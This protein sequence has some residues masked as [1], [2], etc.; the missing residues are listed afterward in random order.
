MLQNPTRYSIDIECAVKRPVII[1]TKMFADRIKHIGGQWVE[2]REPLEMCGAWCS[3][4]RIQNRD[5][6]AAT[7]DSDDQG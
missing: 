6:E 2:N 4:W 5:S 7:V 1:V 3:K